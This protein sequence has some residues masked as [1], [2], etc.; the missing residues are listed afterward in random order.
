VSQLP[1]KPDFAAIEAASHE[2]VNRR[3]FILALIGNLVYSW[4]NNESMFIYVLM[5]LMKTD[6]TSAAVV[7]ATLNTTRARL[8]L[9][10]RLAKINVRDKSVAKALDRIVAKFNDLTKIR[11]EFNHCMY[12]VNDHGEITHTNSIRMHEV[13]GQVQLGI[14][15]KMDDKRINSMLE[16]IRSLTRLNRDIWDF[17]PVLQRHLD[18]TRRQNFETP[19]S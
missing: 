11:N 12:T 9:V 19:P 5:L 13:R 18:E 16:A 2:S 17:L 6:E 4:S 14:V 7:F 8:D 3:T 15:R 1:P 10:D